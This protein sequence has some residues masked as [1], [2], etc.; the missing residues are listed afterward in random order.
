MNY[1]KSL[2]IYSLEDEVRPNRRRRPPF[3]L[4][5][6]TWDEFRNIRINKRHFDHNWICYLAGNIARRVFMEGGD[7]VKHET[8]SDVAG[9]EREN[10]APTNVKLP[11]RR[12][13][14]LRNTYAAGDTRESRQLRHLTFLP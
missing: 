12:H 1:D 8:S 10:P 4:F 9:G 2:L 13:R 5:F 6:S 14:L 7:V 3:F 11:Q